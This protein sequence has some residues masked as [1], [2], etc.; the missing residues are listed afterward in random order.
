M[1]KIIFILFVCSLSLLA[2]AQ[3]DSAQQI[4]IDTLKK[5]VPDTIRIGNMIIVSNKNIVTDKNKTGSYEMGHGLVKINLNGNDKGYRRAT[6]LAI[7][8]KSDNRNSSLYIK[9]FKDTLLTIHND[10]VQLGRLQIIN[11]D[12]LGYNKDLGALLDGDFKK[13]KITFD[14]SPRRLKNISTNWWIF[15][16]GFANYQDNTQNKT[17]PIGN[18]PNS[19][20]LKLNNVK[21]SNV[22]IWIVQQKVN[23]YQHY[24]NLKYGVGIEMYNFRFEQPISFRNDPSNAVYI[25]NVK[26][27]K[28]KLFVE[29]LSVPIQLNFQSNP[30][31]DKSFYAS[32][33]ISPGYLIQSHTK[34]ISE[35]RGKKKVNGNFN[36][37]NYKMATIGE[38]GIGSVRLYGSYNMTNLFDKNYTNLDLMPF[39]IGLRFSKF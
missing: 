15:D 13:T 12:E 26:F 17:V 14:R 35:E 39:A 24:L 3:K 4:K 37:S 2:K 25:D 27:S 20:Y 10:T 23:L 29:Y 18:L 21:S 22:N 9:S 11:K 28:N 1:K 36:L 19:G 6:R 31:N 38:L 32:I 8:E 34:Q 5:E 33:G 7:R 30:N 16:L